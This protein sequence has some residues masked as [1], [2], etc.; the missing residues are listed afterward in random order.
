VEHGQSQV[1]RSVSLSAKANFKGFCEPHFRS[2]VRGGSIRSR[3]SSLTQNRF[4]RMVP[5]PSQ[6]ESNLLSKQPSAQ[7]R[8]EPSPRCHITRRGR[9]VSRG[10]NSTEVVPPGR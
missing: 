2:V 9:P 5:I 10:A 4:L 7:D 6:N 1:W 3:C 8:G